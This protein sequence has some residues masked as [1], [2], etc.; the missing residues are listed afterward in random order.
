MISRTTF[1]YTVQRQNRCDDHVHVVDIIHVAGMH[2]TYGTYV[3]DACFDIHDH[4]DDTDHD[5]DD[6]TDDD[7]DV[8]AGV[9]VGFFSA[10]RAARMGCR[11]RGGGGATDMRPGRCGARPR[12]HEAGQILHAAIALHTKPLRG[13]MGRRFFLNSEPFL[14]VFDK[15]F[16][17]L[18]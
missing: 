1:Y 12:R 7:A 5:T 9:R 13:R 3:D 11:G 16:I 15:G 18:G 4:V 8:D 17:F 2:G 14:V 10:R 6:D